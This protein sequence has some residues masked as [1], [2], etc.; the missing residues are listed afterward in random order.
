MK[1]KTMCPPQQ[2]GET[3]LSLSEPRTVILVPISWPLETQLPW[4]ALGAQQKA[5]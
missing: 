5:Q 1:V 3:F 2:R 4:V